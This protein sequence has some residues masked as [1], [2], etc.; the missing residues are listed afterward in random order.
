MEGKISLTYEQIVF[1]KGQQILRELIAIEKDRPLNMQ[2]LEKYKRI[3]EEL[4]KHVLRFAKTEANRLM[5]KYR[6]ALPSD[7]YS[8]VQQEM[9]IIFDEYLM[10]YDPLQSRPTTY[11]VRLFDLVIT[12][13]IDKFALN[14]KSYDAQNAKKLKVAINYFESEGIDYDEEMLSNRTGLS[15]KVVKQTLYFSNNTK[16]ACVEEELDIQANE[17]SPE[18]E[19]LKNEVE[20]ALYEALVNNL[21]EEQLNIF[22]KRMNFGNEKLLGYKE[23]SEI[24]GISERKIRL[25]INDCLYKLSQDEKLCN[26]YG[27]KEKTKKDQILQYPLAFKEDI[28]DLEDEFINDWYNT[29]DQSVEKM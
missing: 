25:L 22:L 3:K 12:K 7:A 27:K 18:D 9:Y 15:T 24:T 19:Y 14:L 16:F 13:Y 1:Y 17:L 20:V 11:F 29:I 10:E 4:W 23:L 26:A 8:D 6:H 28:D 5:S 21:S 2:E